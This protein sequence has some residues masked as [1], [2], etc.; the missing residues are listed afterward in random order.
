MSKKSATDITVR[1]ILSVSILGFFI[2]GC[3]TTEKIAKDIIGHEKFVKRKMAFLPFA[4]LSRLGG[5]ELQQRLLTQ[6]ITFLKRNCG[7]IYVVSGKKPEAQIT[8]VPRLASGQIDNLA[9]ARV[10]RQL[11]LNAI[12][13]GTISDIQCTKEKRGIWGFRK[14]EYTVRL[15]F[16]LRV[17]DIETMALLL[18]KELEEKMEVSEDEWVAIKRRNSY[19]QQI[20]ENLVSRIASRAGKIICEVLKEQPFKAFITSSRNHEFII[21]AGMDVGLK[22]GDV[23]E[24]YESQG[25]I[26]GKGGQFYLLS[27][28]KTGEVKVIKVF[29]HRATLAKAMGKGFENSS[30]LLLKRMK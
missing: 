20:L 10:G 11:G 16:H 4:N 19:N 15:I 3:A 14:E 13:A 24:V 5:N 30:H 6:L 22:K 18:Y 17:Y 29:A 26:K 23:L 2:F 28:S 12:A 1:I 7:Y 25:T 27:G 21:S 9:M 8:S